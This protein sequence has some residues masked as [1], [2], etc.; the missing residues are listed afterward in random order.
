MIGFS[1]HPK[2]SDNGGLVGI[3]F[4]FFVQPV[5]Q[6]SLNNVCSVMSILIHIM[7]STE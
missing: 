6:S 4:L 1:Q 7:Q 3:L 2:F 5:T